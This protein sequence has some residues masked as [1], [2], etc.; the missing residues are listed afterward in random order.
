MAKR[1][2]TPPPLIRPPRRAEKC[3]YTIRVRFSSAEG[4][5][6]TPPVLSRSDAI[7]SAFAMFAEDCAMAGALFAPSLADCDFEVLGVRL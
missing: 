2:R 5:Y 4:E 7:S 3:R 6:V 1:N